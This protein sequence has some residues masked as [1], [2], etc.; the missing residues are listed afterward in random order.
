MKTLTIAEALIALGNGERLTFDELNGEY[1][2]L[3]FGKLARV[4]KGQKLDISYNSVFES[5]LR[6]YKEFTYPM[7]FENIHNGGIMQF[8]S[9]HSTTALSSVPGMWTK[10][11]DYTRNETHTDKDTWKQIEEPKKMIKV[12]KYAFKD[13]DDWYETMCF[14]QNE[15]HAR[16]DNDYPTLKRLFHTEIEV[17]DY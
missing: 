4:S 9:L 6:I 11:C 14:Y 12:A 15:E 5:N 7:W 3:I 1:I 10:G 16:E 13:D 8:N 2:Q 17:E